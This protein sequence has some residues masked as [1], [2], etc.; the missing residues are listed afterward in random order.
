MHRAIR[1]AARPQRVYQHNTTT[2]RKNRTNWVVTKFMSVL[3]PSGPMLALLPGYLCRILKLCLRALLKRGVC[4]LPTQPVAQL[5]YPLSPLFLFKKCRYYCIGSV[6]FFERAVCN[7]KLQANRL[8]VERWPFDLWKQSVK[9][10]K[11]LELRQMRKVKIDCN[12]YHKMR[13]SAK[14]YL[15]RHAMYLKIVCQN[16]VGRLCYALCARANK[17]Y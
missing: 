3:T 4:L 16:V 15:L 17:S 9:A 11:H 10:E 2:G 8:C 5:W 14:K 12:K 6:D 1:W 7:A 13:W